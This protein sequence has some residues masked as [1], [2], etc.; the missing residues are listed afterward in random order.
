MPIAPRRRRRRI[1]AGLLVAYAL[2]MLFGGCADRLLLHPSTNPIAAP[3]AVAKQLPFNGGSLEVWIQHSAAP[4]GSEPEVF[5]LEFCGNATRAEQIVNNV[6]WRWRQ[7]PAEV[8]V[9]NTPGF[10]GST[11]PASLRALARGA[12]VA[13]DALAQA[14]AGR[15]IFVCGNSMGT[16][17]ALY[18]AANRPVAGLIL[19][20][21]P[22]LRTLI[23]E[24]F[25]WWN[26]WL[27]AG[28][29]ALQVPKELSSIT[30]AARVH[31][32]AVFLMADQDTLVPPR[33]HQMVLDAY[34]GPRH[35]IDL[36]GKGHN[37]GPSAAEDATLQSDIAW[38]LAG[39]T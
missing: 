19:Q 32:P 10:G 16:A 25:G 18:V 36:V 24:R 17:A 4:R 13:Y 30:N 1:F 21:P 37:D 3:G 28:P 5:V 39:G 6:A 34:A 9:V 29:V 26:L 27:L 15:R 35:V 38:L 2:T 20:N 14:A 22:P 11:G 12:L 33:Y 23:M 8:W 7:V 31:A